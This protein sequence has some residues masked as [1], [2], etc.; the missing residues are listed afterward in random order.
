MTANTGSVWD[1]R[2]RGFGSLFWIIIASIFSIPLF[3]IRSVEECSYMLPVFLMFWG[4][5]YLDAWLLDEQNV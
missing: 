4:V 2:G 3:Q 1:L 5:A